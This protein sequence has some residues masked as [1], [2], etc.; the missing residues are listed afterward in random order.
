MKLR[1]RGN[2]ARGT[3]VWNEETSPDSPCCLHSSSSC[4]LPGRTDR[5]AVNCRRRQA[6][7]RWRLYRTGRFE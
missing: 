7:S 4:L 6:S 5:T 3:T 1:E 2:K